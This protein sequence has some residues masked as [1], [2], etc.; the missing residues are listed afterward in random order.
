MPADAESCVPVQTAHACSRPAVEA[1]RCL[2]SRESGLSLEAGPA[3]LTCL[4]FGLRTWEG[5][6]CVAS[7]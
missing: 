1:M 5:A 3:W 2:S 6:W 4:H 7:C